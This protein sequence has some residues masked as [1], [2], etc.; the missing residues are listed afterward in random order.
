M[1]SYDESYKPI[2]EAPEAADVLSSSPVVP[3]Y[4]S[5]PKCIS[6][7]A[8]ISPITSSFSDGF[9]VPIPT[10]VPSLNRFRSVIHPFSYL[11]V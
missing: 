2:R 9:V 7:D 8:L 11:M 4:R 5:P 3:M 1:F 10:L 6:R